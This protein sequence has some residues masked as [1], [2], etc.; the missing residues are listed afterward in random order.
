MLHTNENQK[1]KQLEHELKVLNMKIQTVTANS[2]K[3]HA[4]S[5]QQTK[6]VMQEIPLLIEKLDRLYA[7]ISLT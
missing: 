5:V 7:E 6:I 2:N 4:I 3:L 1:I